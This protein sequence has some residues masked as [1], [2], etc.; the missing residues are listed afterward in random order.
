MLALSIRQP[1]AWAIVHAGKRHE[2]RSW[3][4]AYRGPIAIHASKWWQAQ[5]AL[6]QFASV[7]Y[8][9]GV[10]GV[11]LP[12]ITLRTLRDATGGIVGTARI[13]DCVE[14]SDSPWFVGPF[15]FVLDDVKALPEIIPCKGALG[16][17]NV[18]ADV[19]ARIAP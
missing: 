7:Q 9:A 14:K 11:A 8:A 3:S 18:P 19:A 5:E 4:T 1:W 13:V 2:N 6:D 15:G 10:T 12:P 17:F 16:L